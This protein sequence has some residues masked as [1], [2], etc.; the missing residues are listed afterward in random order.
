MRKALLFRFDT[1]SACEELRIALLGD[2]PRRFA[3]FD[4]ALL[5]VILPQKQ[6]EFRA[7]GHNAVRLGRALRYEIV[8]ENADVGRRAVQNERRK[9][10]N[11]CGG[12]DAR[13]KAL[14][15]GLLV[16]RRAVELPR[17]VEV[18]DVF[19]LQRSEETAR[20]AAV[21]FDRVRVAHDLRIFKPTEGMEH[22]IL[23]L[24]GE[25]GG[26]SLQVDLV[27]RKPHRLDKQLVAL[28][29]READDL[30]LDRG[31]IARPRAVDLPGIERREVQILVNDPVRLGV[32]VGD[33]AGD[34]LDFVER[35]HVRLMGE[36]H[37]QIV[38][39]LDLQRVKING[40]AVDARR[41]TRFEP[42]QRNPG[43]AERLGEVIGGQGIV[44]S[45]GS[46]HGTDVGMPREIRAAGDDDRVGEKITAR[47]G[48]NAADNAPAVGERLGE[49]RGY[50]RLDKADFLLRLD[51]P[52]HV[53][54]I[55]HP[56]CLHA[57]GLDGG[58]F[59]RIEN[60]GLDRRA[61]GGQ[62]H[63]TAQ[64]VDLVDEMPF[65]RTADGRIAGEIRNGIEAHGEKGDVKA[66][67]GGGE[68]G[69]APCVPRADNDDVGHI[70][71]VNQKNQAFWGDL[72]FVP[73]PSPA[74]AR[75]GEAATQCSRCGMTSTNL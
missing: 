12:V 40:S 56:I 45:C 53:R 64:G 21:V 6:A 16:P 60:T 74:T 69:L 72:N 2:E 68:G 36:R 43:I 46:L 41:R 62:R 71:S 23:H 52:F 30:V 57:F 58:A 5:G 34:L 20:I 42:L 10:E 47:R 24:G 22:F 54:M 66:H 8:D 37:D 50:L 49:D 44:R 19:R 25:G 33:V 55:E 59:A 65:S 67:T 38:A 27:G 11:F 70:H 3:E 29:I 9:T 18:F 73:I 51:R 26:E 14:A 15:R 32:R 39:R 35:V 7:R 63:L 28:L 1:R 13:D 75:G 17:A 61:V 48:G 31:A 4:E